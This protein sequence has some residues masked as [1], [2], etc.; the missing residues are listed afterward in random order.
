VSFGES[1]FVGQFANYFLK[2]IKLDF[3]PVWDGSSDK[4]TEFE[5]KVDLFNDD[6]DRMVDNFMFINTIIPGNMSI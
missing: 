5:A 1:S 2:N 4:G 6:I 3:T